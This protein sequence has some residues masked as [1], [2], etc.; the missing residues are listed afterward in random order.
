MI[1]ISRSRIVWRTTWLTRSE[2][3][4]CRLVQRNVASRK[5]GRNTSKQLTATVSPEEDADG[6]AANPR[7]KA[8]QKV[9]EARCNR[10]KLGRLWLGVSVAVLNSDHFG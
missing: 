6:D 3:G 10:G 8:T 4:G 1:V 7:W 2:L 5:I 9:A